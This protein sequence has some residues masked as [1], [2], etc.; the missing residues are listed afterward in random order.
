MNENGQTCLEHAH[1]LLHLTYTKL[2]RERITLDD[3]LIS[4]NI[5][6]TNESLHF[7]MTG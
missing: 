3:T 6:F 4:F 1:V 5:G 7:P 2:T